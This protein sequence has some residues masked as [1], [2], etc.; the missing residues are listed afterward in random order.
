MTSNL[1]GGT[2]DRFEIAAPDCVAE[3]FDGEVVVVNLNTGRYFSIRGLGAA[4]WNDLL[5]GHT[6]ADIRAAL[7]GSDRALAEPAGRFLGSLIEN[8][9]V[10]PAP[11]PAA[12][13]GVLRCVAA[14]RS[15]ETSLTVDA[16]DD[17]KD[18]LLT[19]PIHEV[20]P[21]VGWPIRR[22]AD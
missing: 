16:Y 3:D 1:P 10:R 13:P 6:V 22:R 8:Q 4:V 2:D 21:E 19:D 7:I 9:L 20:D 14:V 5:A 17:M 15:G 12:A 11:P 18:L